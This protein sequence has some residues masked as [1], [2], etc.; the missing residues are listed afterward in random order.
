MKVPAKS[1][2]EVGNEKETIPARGTRASAP[3]TID[4]V[5]SESSTSAGQGVLGICRA[6]QH[7]HLTAAVRYLNTVASWHE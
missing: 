1:S 4:D 6:V 5:N 2:P 3:V 7:N